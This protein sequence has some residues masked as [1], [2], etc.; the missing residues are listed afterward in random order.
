VIAC[1]AEASK[2]ADGGKDG[3]HRRACDGYPLQFE[4]DGAGV[5]EDTR[6]DLDQIQWRAGQRPVGHRLGQ[7]DAAQEGGQVEGQRVQLQPHLVVAE[8]TEAVF[9]I[10]N[11]CCIAQRLRL[12]WFKRVPVKSIPR[13]PRTR[14]FSSV[15]GFLGKFCIFFSSTSST[16]A[17]VFV[18]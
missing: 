11:R 9:D 14:N 3:P 8:P 13:E 1:I 5:T 16:I 15:N 7:L 18:H 10:G 4:G 17:G 6:P 12:S 2:T